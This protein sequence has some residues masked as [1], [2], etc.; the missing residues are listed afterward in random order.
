MKILLPLS[1]GWLL[2]TMALAQS[3]S[4]PALSGTD[5]LGR[6]MPHPSEV[7]AHQNDRYVGV[8]YFLWLNLNRVYD[9]S[10]ILRAH[11]DAR[12]TNAS[13]PWG[14]INAFHFWGEPLF[15][16]YRSDDPWVLRRHAALL[17]D[18]GVDF[19]VFDT[20]NALIYE[21]VV[22]K[23][24]EVFEEQRLLGEHVPKIA[25]MVNTRAG[26][27][28]QKIY[29]WLYQPGRYPELW[30]HW[31]GKPLLLCDPE[32][33]SANIADFF[34]LRKAHWPFELVNT[35]NAWHWEATYPQV[36]SYDGDPSRP[37][38]VN[39]SVGQN[40]HQE[41]GRV[42]MMSTG[43]A[44]GRS[45]HGGRVDD[46]PSAFLSGFNFE[47]QWQRA[48]ELDPEVVFI[49]GWNEWI[50]MQLNKKQ[51]PAVFCDQ[52]DLEF[53]RDVEMMKG[54]YGD[55]Y[56][57]QMAANIRRFKGMKSPA[58]APQ[59]KRIEISRSFAQWQEV[60]PAYG[61]HALDT[62]ARDFPGCGDHHY[63]VDS[64]RNDFKILKVT[65]DQDAIYFYAQTDKN[66][67]PHTDENW[68]WLLI[69][70][71]GTEMPEWEGFNFLVNRHVSSSTET[72]VEVCTGDWDWKPIGDIRYRVEG[73]QM[74]LAIPRRLIGIEGDKF[75]IEFK[76]IDNTQKPGDILDVY[77]NGDAAPGGRFRYRYDVRPQPKSYSTTDDSEVTARPSAG[78]HD[79]SYRGTRYAETRR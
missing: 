24:C 70:I 30:F 79:I 45:F 42:E 76:W 46:R 75:A 73:R 39:V 44:R 27:T 53:S 28:A 69:D 50:A 33:A 56:Y 3:H 18:A 57:M 77:V 67:S 29:E 65:H 41:D 5:A 60:S 48:F 15:G 25:F 64:G 22:T 52:F 26:K 16:Y 20:T 8:F 55:N 43:R 49:T 9:N 71:K 11:P 23:L 78:T 32:K 63:R 35:Q 40:L 72:Q 4:P 37:E 38:Q 59:G 51:G 13:P 21:N 17:S 62:L 74:H 36:Y 19:L 7:R 14:P 68:M 58:L 66:I 54:G 34:T 2:T 10:E 47:E 31:Q 61:D 6:P 1:L 12:Q